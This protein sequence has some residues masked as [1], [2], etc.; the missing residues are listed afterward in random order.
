MKVPQPRKEF[1][2]DWLI[3]I[4][5][6]QRFDSRTGSLLPALAISRRSAVVTSTVTTIAIGGPACKRYRQACALSLSYCSDATESGI[7]VVLRLCR[8]L[9]FFSRPLGHIA[10][11]RRMDAQDGHDVTSATS[12]DDLVGGYEQ[13]VG[14]C[15]AECS[16]GREIEYKFKGGRFFDWDIS[17]LFPA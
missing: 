3:L 1:Q 16:S 14:N 11:S 10:A 15:Q 5:I 7:R 6:R 2:L 9:P 13:G 12:F 8:A 17:R 4:R